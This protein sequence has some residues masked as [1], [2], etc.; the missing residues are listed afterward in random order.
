MKNIQ[1]LLR[2]L[3]S[4]IFLSITQNLYAQPPNDECVNAIDISTAFMGA[5]GDISFNGPFTLTGATPGVDDPPEP[6]EAG[7]CTGEI[8][9]NLFGDDA[10][11]WE[12][13]VWFS[14]TVPDLNGDG[15]S[16]TYSIWTSDGSFG[17]NCGIV[18]PLGGDSDTQVAI[19]QGA[20]P[21]AATGECD[22]YAANEDLFGVEP[23]ISGWQS[24]QFIPGI[25][26]YMGVDGWD[27]V[28]GEFCITVTVCGEQ[29]GDG[30]C[31]PVETYCLCVDCRFDDDGLPICPYGEISAVLY[32]E[33][34]GNFFF[35]NDLT[36][37][38]YFCSEFINGFSGDNIYLGFAAPEF[39]ACNGYSSYNNGLDVSLSVGQFL[40]GATDNGDGSY[41]IATNA[42]YFIELSP[43]DIAIGSITITSF[44]PDGLGSTCNKVLTINFA[45][46]PQIND[47]YCVELSCVAGGIDTTLLEDD[48]VV[49]EGQPFTLS[50]D[51]LE[52]LTLPCNSDDGSSFVYVWVLLTDP[53][54]TGDFVPIIELQPLGTNPTID[55]ST[56]F[57][58]EFGFLPP[59]YTLGSP[60]DPIDPYTGLPRIFQIQGGAICYNSDGSIVD[61]CPA[62]NE[63]EISI[64]TV[65]YLPADD[66]VCS[67]NPQ[68]CTDPMACNYDP[69]VEIDDGSCT[70]PEPNFDCEGNCL[71]AIDC[72]G[73][74]GGTAE[75]DCDD[76]CGGTATEGADCTDANGNIGIYAADC[77][78][79][80]CE[81][82]IVGSITSA[83]PLCD[84]SSINIV[85]IAPDGTS[86]TVTTGTDGTFTVPG[87]PYPCGIYTAAFE[88]ESILPNCYTETG[89]TT[90]ISFEVDGN[91][92]T[93][94]GPNFIANP[95]IPT[96][97]QWGLI[98]LA[99]LLMN[100]GGIQLFMFHYRNTLSFYGKL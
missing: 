38:I 25:T 73:D 77:S 16:V 30:V 20:C 11:E 37:D 9:P 13:S 64:I 92:G 49:C 83:D 87:G 51:G 85:I 48:L 78:C 95:D 58:D 61:G 94:D 53:Y 14:W 44:A 93:N 74:C 98:I 50:T 39:V 8:D 96:L 27:A 31:D 69:N 67:P 15:S 4:L 10:E 47:P 22:H 89:S 43:A 71:V 62:Q 52:D 19:Y 1:K 45:D 70:Y 46:T 7:V 6:G 40:F 35:S 82:E 33:G 12:N 28:Q 17:D 75:V 41:N 24:I 56:F 97:S 88:D 99:L 36:G 72:A 23:W 54:G 63:G 68:G 76:I 2:I 18:N 65:T 42:L 80:T 84:L 86:I 90:P 3:A 55:P 91:S 5:C 59:L 81:E 66:P 29:C 21:T 100:F 79:V 57:I 60:I 34:Q 26:Y 32:D